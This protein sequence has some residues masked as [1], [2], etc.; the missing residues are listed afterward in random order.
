[1][2]RSDSISSPAAKISGGGLI[3]PLADTL[4]SNW[5]ALC[6]GRTIRTHSQIPSEDAIPT[7]R[8]LHW[9][10]LAAQQAIAQ[11]G[12][13]RTILS[14]EQTALVVGTS[15]GPIEQWITHPPKFSN[16]CGLADLAADLCTELGITG[17]RYTYSAA[18]ASGLH[19]L[20]HAA[21]LIQSRQANR[22]LVVGVESSVHPLFLGSFARLRVLSSAGGGCRPFDQRRDGFLMSEAAAAICLEADYSSLSPPP[23]AS[24]AHGTPVIIDK[25]ALGGDATHLTG[26]DPQAVAIDHLLKTV[27]AGRPVDLIHAHGT[28]TMLNDAIELQAIERA[29]ADL[30]CSSHQPILYSH[31]A[32]FGHSLGASGLI[33]ILINWLCHQRS[34]IPPNPNTNQ[35]MPTKRV[36][37]SDQSQRK[38]VHRS[39]AL[40]T[41]F[42]GSCAA[43]SLRSL[44][45]S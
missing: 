37:L 30:D 2:N 8:A 12:W 3:T 33:S 14:D 25:F 42:G 13:D 40:A 7:G 9:A 5:D 43:A 24:M 39:M 21:I 16:L 15:K 34:T 4:E 29:L 32:A 18:C 10:K 44:P 45:S 28:G 17:S 19:A 23:V 27:L 20:I 22:V 11:A 38:P 35:P 1:M 41:G 6:A 26:A 31:K 36:Y